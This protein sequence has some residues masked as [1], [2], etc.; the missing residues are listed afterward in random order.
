MMPSGLACRE[1]QRLEYFVA[2]VSS[3]P[4]VLAIERGFLP[5]REVSRQDRRIEE[6]KFCGILQQL[7]HAFEQTTGAAAVDTAVVEA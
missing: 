7:D 2:G 5:Q 1:G 6:S 3:M 4:S